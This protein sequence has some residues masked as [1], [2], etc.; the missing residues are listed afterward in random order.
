MDQKVTPDVL[1]YMAECFL[2]LSATLQL[3]FSKNDIW[4]STYFIDS[5]QAVFGKPN[6]TERS[7]AHEY[8]KF[9]AQ[10]LKTLAY[11]G[12][13][14]EYQVGRVNYYAVADRIALD[15][16]AVSPQRALAFLQR[17]LTV[18]LQK[19]GILSAFQNF[20][21]SPQ[22]QSDYEMLLDA[23]VGFIIKNTAINK[24]LEIR[25][26]FP[27]VFN[28]LAVE[29]KAHGSVKGKVSPQIFLQSNLLYNQENFRD[30]G[31]AKGKTRQN[32]AATAPSKSDKALAAYL[33]KKAMDAVKR[34]HFPLSEVAG[35][36]S[37]GDATQVHHIFPRSRKAQLTDA[38]ENLVLLT[39]SQHYT[40]AH[41]G[42]KTTS[43]SLDY[44]IRCLEAK[45]ASLKTSLAVSDGFYSLEGLLFVIKIGF[46][47]D[48]DVS[49]WSLGDVEQF[50]ANRLASIE[51]K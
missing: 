37:D 42:N 4:E 39:P 20:F 8:D 16:I 25:R 27:K 23:F 12:V 40:L 36:L 22:S 32:H 7:A 33:T 19:S 30:K 14:T 18:V 9:T 41:P 13:L 5:V 35:S 43:I 26:I 49:V 46:D 29:A 6:P 10:P 21:S 2:N 50:L 51:V 1:S 44:Q 15:F 34:R 11:A 38:L 28:P 48:D 31:K 45:V 17:Y 47:L 24:D 3:H